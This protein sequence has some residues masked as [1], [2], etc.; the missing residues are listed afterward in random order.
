MNTEYREIVKRVAKIAGERGAR[1]VCDYGC[2]NGR[3]IEGLLAAGRS[4]EYTGVDFMAEYPQPGPGARY[5]DRAGG[6]YTELLKGGGKFD[7]VFICNSIPHFKDPCSEFGNITGLLKPG[8]ALYI[9]DIAFTNE[10]EADVA[11]NIDCY[12]EEIMRGFKGEYCRHFYSP[13]EV[14]DLLS[15]HGLRL[16]RREEFRVPGTPEEKAADTARLLEYYDRR[17]AALEKSGQ[18]TRGEFL[19]ALVSAGRRAVLRNGAD[20]SARYGLLFT[21]P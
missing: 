13:D 17:L 3:V 2:G 6:D 11:R 19:K 1:A 7:L 8:G 21:K 10:T 12:I 15:P 4:A 16:A 5:V 18:G 9:D 20:Y 14:I